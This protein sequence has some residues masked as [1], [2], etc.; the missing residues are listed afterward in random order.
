MS[1]PK[2]RPRSLLLVVPLVIIADAALVSRARATGA[3]PNWWNLGVQ[4]VLAILLFWYVL[5]TRRVANETQRVRLQSEAQLAQLREEH[6]SRVAPF[7]VPT[8]HPQI[9]YDDPNRG[10]A[11]YARHRAGEMAEGLWDRVV[12]GGDPIPVHAE[13]LALTRQVRVRLEGHNLAQEVTVVFRHGLTRFAVLERAVPLLTPDQREAEV[14]IRPDWITNAD[15]K[16]RLAALYGTVAANTAMQLLGSAGEHV[17]GLVSR[18]I[19]GAAYLL[20]RRFI[21][22]DQANVQHGFCERIPL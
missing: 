19:S 10:A 12:V 9:R 2:D 14:E 5:E 7:V 15:L 17:V 16:A 6:R 18:D 4:V 20:V 13:A 3:D 8:L 1:I 21:E 22:V 11:E